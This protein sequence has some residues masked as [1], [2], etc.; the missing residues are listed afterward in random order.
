MEKL[1]LLKHLRE[2]FGKLPMVLTFVV[3]LVRQHFQAIRSAGTWKRGELYQFLPDEAAFPTY[4]G[5]FFGGRNFSI[6]EDFE[7]HHFG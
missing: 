5:H 1:E 7:S 6:A 2:I 4:F 3:S